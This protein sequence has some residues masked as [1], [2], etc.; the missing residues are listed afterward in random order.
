M[1]PQA[2]KIR[3]R[4]NETDRMGVVHHSKYFNYF[5]VARIEYLRNLGIN[6]AKLETE[7]IYLAVREVHCKYKSPAHFDDILIIETSPTKVTAAQMELIYKIHN[8]ETAQVIVEGSSTL[9]CLT[10]DFKPRRL[11]EEILKALGIEK[12]EKEIR[13]Q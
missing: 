12:E 4:Y 6:Y 7:G 3:V 5:E 9:V 11:P 13:V 1:K 2:I 8:A 10:A